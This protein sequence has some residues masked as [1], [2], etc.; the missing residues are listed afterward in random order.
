MKVRLA[1]LIPAMFDIAVI[2]YIAY[3]LYRF[4]DDTTLILITVLPASVL[5][6]ILITSLCVV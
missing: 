6:M 3:E 2:I 1:F 4:A 5:V